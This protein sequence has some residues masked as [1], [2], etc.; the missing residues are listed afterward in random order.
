MPR[1]LP[2]GS[3]RRR[4]IQDS[5]AAPSIEIDRDFPI[6]MSNKQKEQRPVQETPIGEVFFAAQVE[7]VIR[8][9]RRGVLI[10]LAISLFSA[11][12][13]SREWSPRAV[14]TWLLYMGV[15]CLAAW[16]ILRKMLA[17][18]DKE[19]KARGWVNGLILG[20]LLIGTGWG[21]FCGLFFPYDNAAQ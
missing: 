10:L 6:R 2:R 17:D 5:V 11:I 9:S 16:F 18:P 1:G 13:F 3:L 14:Y 15:V 12:W 19:L 21:A 8:E 20:S 7:T 4:F